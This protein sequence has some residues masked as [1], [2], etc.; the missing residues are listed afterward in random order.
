MIK[1]L[2]CKWSP[3]RKWSGSYCSKYVSDILDC[4]NDP[5]MTSASA[6]NASSDTWITSLWF[7]FL[8]LSYVSVQQNMISCSKIEESKEH[9]WVFHKKHSLYQTEIQSTKTYQYKLVYLCN[10]ISLLPFT[11]SVLTAYSLELYFFCTVIISRPWVCMFPKKIFFQAL[12]FF[13][14]G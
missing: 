10:I 1:S 3:A 12:C 5:R 11:W 8:V 9:N 7:M 4:S 13:K 2:S 14:E 6:W